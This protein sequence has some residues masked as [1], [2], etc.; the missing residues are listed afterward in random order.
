[1]RAAFAIGGDDLEFEPL[2]LVWVVGCSVFLLGGFHKAVPRVL[3]TSPARPRCLS[4]RLVDG[5][6]EHLSV[7]LVQNE[8]RSANIR[9]AGLS[10]SFE[11]EVQRSVDHLRGRGQG[12][13]ASGRHQLVGARRRRGPAN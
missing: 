7:V 6:T 3:A 1:M 10:N 11:G 13:R 5:Y 4:G 8:R 12:L 2:A 9:I